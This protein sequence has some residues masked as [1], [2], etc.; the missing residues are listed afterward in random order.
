MICNRVDYEY[1]LEVEGGQIW[2]WENIYMPEG[3]RGKSI[4][5]VFVYAHI[6]GKRV[7][8]GRLCV[9]LSHGGGVTSNVPQGKAI[10]HKTQ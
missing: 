5:C 10:S 7:E 9:R 4:E 6:Q 1:I 3:K 2:E 8:I